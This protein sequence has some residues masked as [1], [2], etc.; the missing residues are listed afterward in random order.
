MPFSPSAAAIWAICARVL[1][2]G[3]STLTTGGGAGGDV[4]W[5]V[6]V[7]Q[8]DQRRDHRREASTAASAQAASV[9]AAGRS[10]GSARSGG[11]A[12]GADGGAGGSGWDAGGSG[13]SIGQRLTA[14][15]PSDSTVGGSSGAGGIGG[16]GGKAG[17][18]G[19]SAQLDR[20]LERVGAAACALEAVALAFGGGAFAP[21]S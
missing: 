9:A 12:A 5:A 21:W 10:G 7:Q 17:P 16:T 13:C 2:S 15:P 4:L 11:W 8:R 14:R 6:R 3:I 20:R 1:P 19:G 18:V